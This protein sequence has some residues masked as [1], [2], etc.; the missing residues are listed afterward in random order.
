MKP[1]GFKAGES[2]LVTWLAHLT[3][4]YQKIVTAAFGWPNGWRWWWLGS[5]YFG[6][7]G[8]EENPLRL[9]DEG[10]QC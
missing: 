8:V 3:T 9:S 6:V 4:N 7:D 2:G 1:D 5:L 10:H